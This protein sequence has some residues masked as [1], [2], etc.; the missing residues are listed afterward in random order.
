MTDAPTARV[1]R[2][3]ALVLPALAEAG[4][5]GYG[6]QAR[7]AADTG[8]SSSTISRLF[9]GE[10][11]P[12]LRFFPALGAAA[13]LDPVELLVAAEIL[14]REYLESYQTLSETSR[15][16]VGSDSITPEEAAERL[17]IRGDVGKRMFAAMVDTLRPDDE[18][19]ADNPGGKAAQM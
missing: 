9:K 11:I 8:M 1:A 7:L 10:T 6:R 17:G 3:C 19:E 16:Q 18:A 4:Y 15:S 12:D 2:F 14:P 13:R 5:T